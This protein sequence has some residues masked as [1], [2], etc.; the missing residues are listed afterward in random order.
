MREQCVPG[1]PSDFSSAWNEANY[2]IY[3]FIYSSSS[4]TYLFK[5]SSPGSMHSMFCV[6]LY[7]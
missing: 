6:I 3:T 1:A 7:T 4:N 2:N 5:I